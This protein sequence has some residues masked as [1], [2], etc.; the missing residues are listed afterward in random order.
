MAENIEKQKGI[1]VPEEGT[2][3]FERL[4]AMAKRVIPAIL[5]IFT[6]G[7]LEQQAFGMIFVNIGEM[8]GQANLSPLITSIPGIVLGIVCVIYASLGDFISLRKMTVWGTIFF[9]LGSVIG[10]L[11]GPK[12]IWFVILARVIQSAGWQVT[13]SVFLVLVSKYIKEKNRVIYYSIFTVVF[14]FAA[15]LGVLFAGYISKIDWK[16]LFA[17]PI[18]CIVLV[19]YLAKHLP[20]ESVSGANIDY[21]G[22][23]LVGVLA[24]SIT[25]FFTDMNLFWGIT[26]ILSIVAFSVY[27]TK[28]KNPFITPEF[29]K[30]SAFIWTMVVIF[31]GYFFSYTL[32][33]G[34]NAI[35]LNVYNIDSAEVSNLLVWSILLAAVM[36]FV[37]GPVIQ[38]IGRT[39]SII[40]ALIFMGLGPILVGFA[41]P[42]GKVWT[43]AIAPCV[44]YFGTAFFYSPIVDTATLTVEP[45]ESGRVLGVNDLVQAVTGSIG[46]SFFG[47][48]M[49]NGAMSGRSIANTSSGIA[50]TYANVF[51]LGGLVVLSGLI[52]F[53]IF[54]EKIYSRNRGK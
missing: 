6:F 31:L 39:K 1:S 45:E 3:E 32:N 53:L 8:L 47:S 15:A 48:L 35:G 43:L 4:N 17:A 52:V 9:V 27:I 7:T 41:I 54:K 20:D 25:M 11:L 28:A 23:A 18:I 16:L 5:L 50:S 49:T 22:F 19:P 36:G 12:N 10:W 24:G 44:Y 2:P 38:K 40:M 33:A 29:F 42:Y 14:R 46:V 37:A 21:A 51:I 13:G 26:S 30:N 34:I